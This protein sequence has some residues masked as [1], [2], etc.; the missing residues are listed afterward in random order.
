MPTIT[1]DQIGGIV[2]TILTAGLSYAVG[3]GFITNDIAANIIGFGGT[4]AMA[5]WSAYTNR[6][7]ALRAPAILLK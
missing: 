3:K 6:A 4:F 5:M 7:T 2:R 1:G